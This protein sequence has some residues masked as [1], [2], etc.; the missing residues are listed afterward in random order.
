MTTIKRRRRPSTVIALVNFIRIHNINGPVEIKAGM[1]YQG[2]VIYDYFGAV[3]GFIPTD[4]ELPTFSAPIVNDGTAFWWREL[5]P[6]ELL[7]LQAD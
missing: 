6:L 7:A 3:C 5:S 1:I 2:D 4:P